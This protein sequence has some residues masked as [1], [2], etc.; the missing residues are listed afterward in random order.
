MAIA[1]INFRF[2]ASSDERFL[3]PQLATSGPNRYV[4]LI[5][6]CVVYVILLTPVVVEDLI[7]PRAAPTAQE[8]PVEIVVEPPPQEK[9]PGAPAAKS[10]PPPPTT[11]TLDE[12]PAFDAPRAANNDKLDTDEAAKPMKSP[13][14]PEEKPPSPKPD[15]AKEAKPSPDSEPKTEQA[16]T[17]PDA[18]VA[19]APPDAAGEF[20]KEK[21][22]PQEKQAAIEPQPEARAATS[23]ERF[24][25]FESVPDIDFG[26]LAKPT[27]IAR[28]NAKATYLTIV[29][30]MIIAHA[31]PVHIQ[32]KVKGEI[33]FTIDAMG[34][35]IQRK[36]TRSSGSRE[37]DEAA[38]E[39]ITKASPFPPPPTHGPIGLVFSY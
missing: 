3:P 15:P 12:K 6:A 38:S 23:A 18:P 29:Y 27:P 4:G 17:Q 28:G 21:P 20:T 35:L 14:T 32:T 11:Q 16:S 34:G 19:D 22:A 25:T 24:P 31:P 8:I 39:A 7:W 26:A 2:R 37:L 1:S 5:G 36:L 13:A 9:P 33:A 10:E 30:G